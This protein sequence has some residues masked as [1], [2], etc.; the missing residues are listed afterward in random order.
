MLIRS[1]TTSDVESIF[2]IMKSNMQ[3]YYAARGE[4]WNKDSI[5]RYFL[6]MNSAVVEHEGEICAFTFYECSPESI[7]IHTFQV[8]PVRQNG[9]LGG[10]LFRWYLALAKQ[11]GYSELSCCVYDSNPALIMYLK[12]GFEELGRDNGTVRLSLPV[13]KARHG[14]R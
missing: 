9:I 1:I 5:R 13:N 8:A 14:D 11:H 3:P 10:K 6:G 12:M 4:E 7:H 2:T